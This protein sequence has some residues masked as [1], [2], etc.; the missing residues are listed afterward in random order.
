MQEENKILTDPYFTEEERSWVRTTFK[1]N[2]VAMKTLRKFLLPVLNHDDPIG[3]LEDTWKELGDNVA[4]IHPDERE[5]AILA[6]FKVVEHID[7]NLSKI[8]ILAGAV[9]ESPEQ[10]ESRM[11]K[12]SN[13]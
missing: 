10:K 4:K 5:K 11:S 12:D 2:P 6:H 8:A 1:D 7:R 9:E 3:Q 13:Q